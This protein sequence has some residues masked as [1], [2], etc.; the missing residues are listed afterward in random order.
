MDEEGTAGFEQTTEK[1]IS[2]SLDRLKPLVQE[3]M[4]ALL[5]IKRAD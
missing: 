3:L 1:T 5:H 4:E 2:L